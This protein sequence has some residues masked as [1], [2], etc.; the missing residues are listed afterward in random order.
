VTFQVGMSF[1]EIEREM[2]L[3][4]LAEY[5]NNKRQAARVLGIT[6]KT[7][8]NRLLRYRE[9]GLIG[10]ELLGSADDADD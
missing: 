9:Q 5:G 8:Y 10:D 4:T 6:P 2:L 3:R 1:E 7:V